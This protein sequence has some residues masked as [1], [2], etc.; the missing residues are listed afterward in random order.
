MAW[1]KYTMIVAAPYVGL[2]QGL[3]SSMAGAAGDG[4][5]TTGLSATGKAPAT[6]YISNGL[7]YEEFGALL[8]DAQATYDAAGG[9]VPLADIQALYANSI[10]VSE[11][12][13]FTVMN[14]NGLQLIT[15]I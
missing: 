12:D 10:I 4:M 7:I 2:A 5:W 9:S 6:H 14:D 8:G 15:E 3:S 1:V 13:P 11:G